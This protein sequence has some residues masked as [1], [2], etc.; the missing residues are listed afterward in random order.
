MES[1]RDPMMTGLN[2][3][4]CCSFM[5]QYRINSFP[6]KQTREVPKIWAV[7]TV[8][9]T[10]GKT[11][12]TRE[13]SGVPWEPRL[14]ENY[15]RIRSDWFKVNQKARPHLHTAILRHTPELLLDV[16][17]TFPF[18]SRHRIA[19]I[20][21]V[22]TVDKKLLARTLLV[23]KGK[24]FQNQYFSFEITFSCWLKNWK[25]NLCWGWKKEYSCIQNS[26]WRC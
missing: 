22:C 2:V 11:K 26:K 4:N 9:T 10:R 19:F 1:E 3:R 18:L 8:Q 20:F 14:T 12:Y 24:T 17:W 6:S 21:I 15:S 25:P 13:R 5:S 16:R 7:F 23:T